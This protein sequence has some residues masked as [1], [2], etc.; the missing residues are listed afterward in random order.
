MK[1]TRQSIL[2]CARDQYLDHGLQGV[3]MRKVATLV[4]ITPMAIYRHF[5]N[6]EDLL[7]QLLAK[8]FLSFGEYLN[9]ALE[10]NTALERMQMTTEAYLAF[11]AEQSKYFEIIFLSTGQIN[12]L[13]VKKV[14]RK[15]AQATFN[16][17]VSRVD[18]C[19]AAGIFKQDSAFHIAVTILAEV[20]GLVSLHLSE[21]F[22]WSQ[23]EFEE[24][25][26][27]SLQKIIIGFCVQPKPL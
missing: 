25:F 20:N 18:E 13:K 6:K 10:G 11:A 1:D 21:T 17:L 26:H 27:S 15:E 5:T 22:N 9:R 14:I 23:K 24:L 12:E 19:L 2:D 3:S 4:G 8:G 7:E 16:F